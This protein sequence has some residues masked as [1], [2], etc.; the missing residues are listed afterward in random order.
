MR[1]QFSLILILFLLTYNKSSAQFSDDFT[2]GNFT[3]NPIWIGESAKFQVDA[4]N[5]LQLND[6]TASSPAFLVTNSTAIYN[7]TWQFYVKMDFNPSTS[8]YGKVMLVSNAQDITT[9]FNGYFVQIGGATGTVDDVSLYRQDGNTEVKIIDGVDGTAATNPEMII[10]VTRDSI[11]NW[12]LFIDPAAAGTSFVS[13]GTVTDTTYTQSAFFG[14]E[15]IYTST[16]SDKFFFDD[17]IVTGTALQDNTKP[18]FNTV[19]VLSNTELEIKFSEKVTAVTAEN[20]VNYSVDLGVGNPQTAVLDAQDS[21]KV[22]LTFANPFTNAQTYSI[23]V[24]NV[25]DVA[26]NVMD[27][28]S[29]SFLYFVPAVANFKEV[30]IT[31]LFPDPTPSAGLPEQ[32]FIEIYNVSNKTF[33]L[34]NWTITDGSSTATLTTQAIVPNEYVIICANANVSLFQSFGTVVGVSGFPTL[35]NSGDQITLRNNGATLIDEVNYSDDWYQD[36]TKKSGGYT[37]ELIN[38]ITPCSDAQNWIASKATIGGTP[39]TQNSVFSNLIDSIGPSLVRVLI[40][41]P[42]TLVL[43]FDELLDSLSVLTANYTFSSGNTAAF[44]ANVAPNY[45]RV[46]IGLSAPLTEGVLETITVTGITDCS[47]NPI[48]SANTLSF[49]LPES[50]VAGDII[51]N[52]VLFNPRT[53]GADFVEIY[54]NSQKA[55]SLQ[56]WKLANRNEGVFD[57]IKEISSESYLLLPGEYTVLTTNPENI[58]QEYPLSFSDRMLEMSSLPSMNDSEGNIYLLLEDTIISDFFVYN[59][60]LHL[61]LLT[62]LNGV[63]LERISFDRPTNELGTWHSASK[64]FGYATPTYKNSQFFGIENSSSTLSVFPEVFSPDG[65]GFEDLV[66]FNYN[67]DQPGFI[68][69]AKVYDAKGRLVKEIANNE[70]VGASGNLIWDGINENNSKAAIGPYILLFEAF[71]EGGSTET[72]KKTFVLGGRL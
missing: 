40:Q 4:Q 29:L 69:T 31:E 58:K 57:N 50:P 38:P 64:S 65:D 12:E 59:D 15:C 35:N 71:T 46:I 24:S 10:R 60:D 17:F 1:I 36:A 49:A 9:N 42:D 39:G 72:F 37:L 26:A 41:S 21:S 13:Q 32:E 53:G 8:N 62:D 45:T 18:V 55:I 19:S 51:L 20:V 43:E 48:G 67:F 7:A 56:G 3:A 66:S 25:Q 22:K 2:D 23:T 30:I 44:I 47:G 52:E 16:R 54:N 34:A 14:V 33:D 11:G 6:A 61:E 63:S 28:K 27:T 5:Q 70:V 68:V